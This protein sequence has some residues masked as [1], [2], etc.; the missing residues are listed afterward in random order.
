MSYIRR[1]QLVQMVRVFTFKARTQ[2]RVNVA[3]SNGIPIWRVLRMR[4]MRS[5]LNLTPKGHLWEIFFVL[6]KKHLI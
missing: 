3:R 4:S 6:A 5:R 2:S 1:E